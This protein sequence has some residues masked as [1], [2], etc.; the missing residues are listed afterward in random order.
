MRSFGNS[1]ILVEILDLATTGKTQQQK[2]EYSQG[3]QRMGRIQLEPTEDICNVVFVLRHSIL[4]GSVLKEV[5]HQIQCE[6]HTW[7]N[8]FQISLS[9]K[10]LMC[11]HDMH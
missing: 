1:V 7:Q 11:M 2:E 3:D 9:V 5:R 6:H 4:Q 8:R 10:H